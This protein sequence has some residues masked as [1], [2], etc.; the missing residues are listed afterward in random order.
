MNDDGDTDDN[1]SLMMRRPVETGSDDAYN[2][3]PV[4]VRTKVAGMK[5]TK[6]DTVGPPSLRVGKLTAQKV[7]DALIT[8]RTLT[9]MCEE[10]HAQ[11]VID[12]LNV[13]MGA[14]AVDPKDT[15]AFNAA[16][17]SVYERTNIVAFSWP[18][19]IQV[20]ALR[21]AVARSASTETLA[22]PE[23]QSTSESIQ[24][25][26]KPDTP[27]PTVR[28]G[29]LNALEA[30]ASAGKGLARAAGDVAS[31]G[32]DNDAPSNEAV[33]AL[34]AMYAFLTSVLEEVIAHAHNQKRAPVGPKRVHVSD[35]ETGGVQADE[36]S[37]DEDDA[38]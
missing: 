3:L 34:R 28:S 21:Q 25:Q 15:E 13:V 14:L 8:V 19:H 36:E 6:F 37:E 2:S 29:P 20:S 5:K 17:A 26:P 23:P 31:A 24:E 32:V 18:E 12:Y 38:L 27:G 1:V 35:A 22:A 7:L 9:A 33:V 16:C 4:A 10:M 11:I 30:M